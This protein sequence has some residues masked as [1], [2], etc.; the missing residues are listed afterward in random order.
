M[1]KIH[2]LFPC[3]FLMLGLFSSYAQTNQNE[4]IDTRI[5]NMRYW[6]KSAE[7]GIIPF[8]PEI[9]FKPA[10]FT[11]SEIEAESVRN[12]NSPDVPVTS[13]NNVTQSENS[14]FVD[15]GDNNYVLNSNNSTSWSGGSVGSLYGANY[16][17][18]ADGGLTWGG[19]QQGAGGSNSGDPTTAI[20]HS[21][22]QFVGYI[23]D[24]YGQGVSYSDNGVNWTPV[25]VANAPGGWG[26]LLDKN[27]LWIDN[28]PTSFYQGNLYN[29]WTPFGGTN[30]TE[31]EIARSSDDGVSWSSVQNIS[32]AVNAG[33]H[34]QGVHIQ[35]GPDGEVYVA[36]SIYDSWPSDETAIG[37]AK[38]TNGGNT[39]TP[40]TRIITNIKG[41][42]NSETSKN[43]RVNS[44]PVMAA[45][46][47]TGPYRGNIYIVWT[48]I[49]TPGI[50]SGT[51]RSVY[52]SRSEDGGNTW[53]SPVRVNQGPFQNGKEAY[54][55]WITCDPETGTLSVVFYDD[56]NTSSSSCEVFV[57][58]SF[59]AG[60]T[61]EDF[62]VS[63][64][65]F[66][67]APIPGLAGGYMGDYLGIA[68]RGGIVYPCWTDNR[69]G[70]YMT[71][72]SPFETNNLERPT[73][74][75]ATLNEVTGQVDLS[76]NFNFV[77]T[78]QTFNIY[79][80]GVLL[81]TTNTTS[82]T[83]N[84]PTYGV[85]EY[86]VSA[87]HADGESIPA[88]A[89]VQ[90]GNP[91]ISVDPASFY[92]TLPPDMT[93][94]ESLT[95]SNIGELDLDFSVATVINSDG[96]KN[97]CAASG[98]CDEYIS[99]V[100]LNTINNSSGCGGY[101]DYTSIS[102]TLNA[103]DTYDIT[104][105]NGQVWNSDDLGVWIDWNQDGDFADSGENVVCES[106][107]GGQGTYSFMVPNNALPGQ[108]RMRVRIKYFGSDCG[109]PC[110]S[111][112]YGEVEDYS[113]NVQ[114]WLNINP[115]SGT[116]IPGGS[117]ALDVTFD[118]TGLTEGIYNAD[119]LVSS[120][121]PNTS[122]VTVPATLNVSLGTPQIAVSPASL[123]FG[124][125]QI[126]SSSTLQF[127]I[128]NTGTGVLSGNI[129][130]PANFTVSSAE[131]GPENSVS[132]NVGE[133]ITKS[134]DLTFTPTTVQSYSGDVEITH[135]AGGY[136]EYIAVTGNGTPGPAPDISIA[137]EQFYLA[138][139]Q[140][141]DSNR[142]MTISNLGMDLLDYSATIV[143]GPSEKKTSKPAGPADGSQFSWLTITANGSGSVPGNNG[144]VDV[145]L[146]FDATGL[147]L[148]AY[149]AQVLINSNDPYDPLVSVP[150]TLE[151][152][153]G[154]HV[155]LKAWLE[156]PFNGA[157]MWRF[158]NVYGYLPDI[159]PFNTYPW[160]YDGPETASPIPNTDIVDWVLVE[161]RETPGDASTAT[162][163]TIVGMQAGFVK[164]DGSIVC[165]DGVNPLTFPLMVNHNLYAVVWH[166]N[167]LGIL[168]GYP[169]TGNGAVY[170]YDFTTSADQVYGSFIAH[171]ELA[172]G[173]WGM[174]GGDGNSNGMVNMEDKLDVWNMEVGNFGYM[175]GDFDLNGNVD[176][177]DK[178]EVW[179]LNAGRGSQVV[180]SPN[181]GLE[182]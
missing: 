103:G 13:L 173:V 57:A 170:N 11:G 114:G 153:D 115:L 96:N 48:N 58:N 125:V 167:H 97:Y 174:V 100:T 60:N 98:G 17:Q 175:N 66:T 181:T 63:D 46:I 89:S 20:N 74:L 3:F 19:S 166:R 70:L 182:Y 31:I 122:V 120:N 104:V 134:F 129:T 47:S 80:D 64:V 79:R 164:R 54:F 148:G 161:L 38:S 76:W 176:N 44:F 107:N 55:P 40:A 32:S 113:V 124:D 130:T 139:F 145:T 143:Y 87:Q 155:S 22:R 101:E 59:D 105:V 133:G 83:D 127:T 92:V 71:Y 45:D 53:I 163:S 171:K 6:V 82:F 9:P 34:N 180:D 73:D 117:M 2:I 156:G 68:A 39:Y 35:T 146:N 136:P 142:I 7:K 108:T 137:P 177:S 65:S 179:N 151:V 159:Q 61:W 123:S 126:G 14:V 162:S 109:D 106:G 147:N 43:H 29:A 42:R 30:D 160:F 112:S 111:T 135:N 84:L 56:R 28:S 138:L 52:M 27:H 10:E 15:P 25:L 94:V 41:I 67:P 152:I 102:T 119:V 90:W 37:F 4:S 26:S 77:P 75:I 81:G 33:S 93:T 118:A 72:V 1:K 165:T 8:N 51:N 172:P 169:L 150:C 5:D 24:N 99:Q 21:G 132:F 69:G 128:S 85:Y 116:V 62:K 121:D 141:T 95:I 78:F 36:W 144:S 12:Q 168:S 86:K 157:E 110:G 91:G 16:F 49:G 131:N 158:L 149:N 18:S 50:N 178:I 88:V 140:D 154:I 23:H